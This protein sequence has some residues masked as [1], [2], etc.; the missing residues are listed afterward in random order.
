MQNTRVC[1]THTCFSLSI[2]FA[3]ETP[4]GPPSSPLPFLHHFY[5]LFILPFIVSSLSFHFQFFFLPLLLPRLSLSLTR[6]DVLQIRHATTCLRHHVIAPVHPFMPSHPFRVRRPSIIP[7]LYRSSVSPIDPPVVMATRA[8]Q[9]CLRHASSRHLPQPFVKL[10]YI[11]AALSAS[12]RNAWQTIPLLL[13]SWS[14]VSGFV[15]H[16]FASVHRRGIAN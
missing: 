5:F 7:S 16:V 15:S 2:V 12:A 4:M 14:I 3:Q 8:G 1:R 9:T 11:G 10:R 13:C 6:V